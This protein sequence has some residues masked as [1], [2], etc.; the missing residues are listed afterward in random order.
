MPSQIKKTLVV[1]KSLRDLSPKKQ[2]LV[3]RPLEETDDGNNNLAQ[4]SL[5]NHSPT[6]SYLTRLFGWNP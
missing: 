1:V 2:L 5:G 4:T 6:V 3:S